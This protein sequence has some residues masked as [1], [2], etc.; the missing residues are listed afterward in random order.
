MPQRLKPYTKKN[1]SVTTPELFKH[2][3][4]GFEQ[5]FSFPK[6]FFSP[7]ILRAENQRSN[8]SDAVLGHLHR[9]A[10][11]SLESKK[12]FLF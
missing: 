2:S 6:M 10:S 1:L 12:V 8:S 4:E 9:Y 5:I 11:E 7:A 3:T